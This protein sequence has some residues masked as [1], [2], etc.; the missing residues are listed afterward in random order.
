MPPQRGS[1]GFPGQCSLSLDW[2]RVT[3]A[4]LALRS[5]LCLWPHTRA[6]CFLIL[7]QA[8][9]PGSFLHYLYGIIFLKFLDCLWKFQSIKKAIYPEQSHMCALKSLRTSTI[10]HMHTCASTPQDRTGRQQRLDSTHWTPVHRVQW[11][12]HGAGGQP[13]SRAAVRAPS[14]ALPAPC[15]CCDRPGPELLPVGV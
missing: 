1:S 6:G 2:P 4:G 14:A 8:S 13:A 11:E 10:R 15:S 7:W 12:R 9:C 5:G 3:G